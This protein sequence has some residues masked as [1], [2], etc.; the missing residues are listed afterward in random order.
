MI[1]DLEL[2]SVDDWDAF[3][4]LMLVMIATYIFSLVGLIVVG[5]AAI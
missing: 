5:I 3:E 4:I 1:M 2:D